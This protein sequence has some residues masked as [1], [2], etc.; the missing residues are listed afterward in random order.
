MAKD[1]Y[2]ILGVSKDASESEIKKAFRRR[3]RELHPDVNKAA[4]AEDQFKELNEAYDVLSDPNKRA[5]YDR[6]GTIPGAAGGGY[7]GGSGYVDFDDLFGGGFGGMGDIF[8]SFFGGQGGQGGRPA[9]KEGRDMGVGL[10]I[11]LEEVA[12]GVE[13]EIVYDRLAPCPD[14]KGTGL[15]ENGKV[16]TCP[17]CGGKGRVVSVQR[18]F[19]GDMQTATTCK[20][21]NGTG[22][23][24][25][26]PCP[27]CEG[28]GRVPDRQ[29]VTVKVPAGIRDGQQL[30]VGGFG[31]AGIQ[32]AQAGD[33]IVT[34]RVQPHE[35]FER[36]GDDLHGRANI[37]FIQA[38]LGA[39]IEIDGIMP[40]EKVQVRIPAGCQNEQVVRVKGFGMPRLK[41][42]IRGSMYVHVNVVIPEKI[43]KKQRELLEKLADEMG[44]EVAAP[45][46]PL[47]K[48]RDAFN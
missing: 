40:D 17:E 12:R 5:Q 21:C 3:A 7:G 15:G 13:K 38:I 42:D 37:S 19:L 1:L 14:C 36:D 44:E 6:F 46:S 10:R 28:Q 25:E 23:S 29:R 4:D 32:G 26:N 9:R 8:S 41:S 47:Q 18:T 31:E 43:T 16:V 30:R 45:R 24:I 11:T 39:E 2:E 35:F 33:L 27:E 22:S 20:K 48:L 34:C